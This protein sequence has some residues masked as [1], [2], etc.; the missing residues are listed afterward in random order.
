MHVRV[1]VGR[2]RL[3][4]VAVLKVHAGYEKLPPTWLVEN[5]PGDPVV[6]NYPGPEERMIVLLS[7]LRRLSLVP[8]SFA[9]V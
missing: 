1:N 2:S 7:K 5:V 3:R 8:T 4:S 9:T 6:A